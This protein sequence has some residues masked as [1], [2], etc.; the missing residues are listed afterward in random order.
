MKKETKEKW[1]TFFQ[2]PL[3]PKCKKCRMFETTVD[4]IKCPNCNYKR[5]K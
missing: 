1:L 2:G 4:Y 5:N 3:C